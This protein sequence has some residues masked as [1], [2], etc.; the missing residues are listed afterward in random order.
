MHFQILFRSNQTP[1]RIEH[2]DGAELLKLLTDA[3]TKDGRQMVYV[4]PLCLVEATDI[5]AF[6]PLPRKGA[7]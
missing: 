3:M 1:L 7:V 5:I 2:P 6:G 4:S